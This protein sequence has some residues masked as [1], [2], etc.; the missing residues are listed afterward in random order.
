MNH[1]GFAGRGPGAIE[2]AHFDKSV[3]E[4]R[5]DVLKP[6]REFRTGR[7]PGDPAG[8]EPLELIAEQTRLRLVLEGREAAD[9]LVLVSQFDPPFA[10]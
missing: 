8:D 3:A 5:R 10:E 9:H 6:S 7:L 1:D 4:L 2:Q